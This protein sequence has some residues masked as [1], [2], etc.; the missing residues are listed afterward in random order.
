MLVSV[1]DEDQELVIRCGD[2][3]M[4]SLKVNFGVHVLDVNLLNALHLALFI[5]ILILLKFVFIDAEKAFIRLHN[6]H[7]GVF[8]RRKERNDLSC[9]RD[10][11]CITQIIQ[12]TVGE[13]PYLATSILLFSYDVQDSG[14]FTVRG[15]T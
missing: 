6:D 10:W 11:H 5:S 1:I 3:G 14:V 12:G 15:N 2:C 4:Q 13:A 8:S 7:L 9:L